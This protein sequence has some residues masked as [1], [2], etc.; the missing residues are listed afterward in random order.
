MKHFTGYGAYLLFLALR[1]HFTKVKYDYFKMNGKLRTTKET[2][3]KRKDKIFFEKLAKRYN[4]EELKTFYIA[5]FLNDVHYVTDMLDEEAHG[6]YSELEKRKQSLSYIFKNDMERIFDSDCSSIFRNYD[7]DYPILIKSLLRGHISLE[8]AIILNDFIPYFNKFDKY[9]GDDDVIWSRVGL[10]LRKYR[11][12]IKYDSKKF[13]TILKE[14]VH[15][16]IR[17]KGI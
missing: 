15:E 17:R 6:N 10:K 7:D 1:T 3:L 9:L 16:N 8:S 12:F 5:N 11:P 14:T 13:K 2:Y 4:S